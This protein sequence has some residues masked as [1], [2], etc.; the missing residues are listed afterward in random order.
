M[1]YTSSS[2]SQETTSYDESG[3]TNDST[4][5]N[6]GSPVPDLPDVSEPNDAPTDT[7]NDHTNMDQDL[8]GFGA[9]F[10]DKK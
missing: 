8:L 3:T 5:T 10:D 9:Q 4:R 2:G 1:S 7:Q 6:R